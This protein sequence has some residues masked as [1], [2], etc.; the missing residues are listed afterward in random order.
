MKSVLLLPRILITIGCFVLTSKATAYYNPGSGKWLS[1]DPIGERGG[2]NLYG[3]VSNNSVGTIDYL[4][5]APIQ[6]VPIQY[7]L[8]YRTS[9]GPEYGDCGNARWDID[10]IVSSS[11]GA[12]NANGLQIYQSFSIT[13]W[14]SSCDNNARRVPIPARGG[15]ELWQL[16]PQ[17]SALGLRDTWSEGN[18][19]S[20]IGKCSGEV[21]I[22][23]TAKI[24]GTGLTGN[25]VLANPNLGAN[26]GPSP[27][28]QLLGEGR[29]APGLAHLVPNPNPGSQFNQ[30]IQNGVSHSNTVNREWKIKWNCCTGKKTKEVSRTPDP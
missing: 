19:R 23:G 29:P 14:V 15:Q 26:P 22:V 7:T 4:G 2:V 13:G 16:S 5:N 30:E 24:I 27:T 9:H 18:W 8:K 25:D 12:P 1:R 11:T 28:N 17:G 21:A 20:A 6:A 3:F 10:W